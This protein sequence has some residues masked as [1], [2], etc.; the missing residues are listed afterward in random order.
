MPRPEAPRIAV[1]PD[2]APEWVTQAVIDGG[3][4]LVPLQEA[5][6]LVWADPRDAAS[7]ARTMEAAPRATWIQLPFAGIENFVH[8]V[9]HDHTWTCG[10]G[11]YAE[12]VAELALTLGLAGMRG[13]VTYARAAQWELKT[14]GGSMGPRAHV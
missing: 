7:L 5:E 10:K 9:D 3:G 4:Y 11:V 14:F 1:A 6:G 12:P 2:E 8:L 13:L